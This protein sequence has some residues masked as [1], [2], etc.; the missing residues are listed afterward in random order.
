MTYVNPYSPA[1]VLAIREIET[2][3]GGDVL[4]GKQYDRFTRAF[5]CAAEF[6]WPEN[7]GRTVLD[8]TG[9]PVDGADITTT[10]WT[11]EEAV[12]ALADELNVVLTQTLEAA[13]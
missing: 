12:Q 9:L 13:E 1:I 8:L 3:T 7:R 4:L 5:D 11:Y 6:T 2:A 10:G